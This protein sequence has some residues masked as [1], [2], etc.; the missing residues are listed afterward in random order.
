MV[1]NHSRSFSQ[2]LYLPAARLP[3]L[4]KLVPSDS[5]RLTLVSPE[6]DTPPNLFGD[7][8]R[9]AGLM[10]RAIDRFDLVPSLSGHDFGQVRSVEH[11]PIR[12]RGRQHGSSVGR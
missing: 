5:A 8:S 9:P 6:L 10:D 11:F 2:P 1:L 4:C 12:Y 7:P 3:P